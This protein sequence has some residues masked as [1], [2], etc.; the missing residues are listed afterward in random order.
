MR[1]ATRLIRSAL[2]NDEPPYF[3][4]TSATGIEPPTTDHDTACPAYRRW[5]SR[6]ASP[7]A[8]TCAVGG[9]E[10]V[11]TT[12]VNQRPAMTAGPDTLPENPDL[13]TDS[14][15]PSERRAA[16]RRWLG[17]LAPALLYLGI[18]EL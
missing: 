15:S 6:I 13:A 3:W 14:A 2:S 8:C 4:T 17:A 5:S 16:W 12:E 10:P 1:S 18:R 7:V 11:S 9:D